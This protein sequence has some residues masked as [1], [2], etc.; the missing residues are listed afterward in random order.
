MAHAT[1]DINAVRMALGQ[2][3]V[4]ITDSIFIT[5]TALIFMINTANLKLTVLALLPLPFLTF[6]VSKFSKLLHKRFKNVQE[7][8]SELTDNTQ[9]SFAG[10][11]VIKSFVQEKAEIDKF[12]KSNK[13]NFKKNIK[14]AKV[15]GLFFPLIHL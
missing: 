11:R 12:A 1:N 9:E 4:L 7:A 13:N 10:I 3:V 6:M 15:M 14:L 2:G 8:F 5:I